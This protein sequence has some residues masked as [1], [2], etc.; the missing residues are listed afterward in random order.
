MGGKGEGWKNYGKVL[1]DRRG[2][3][4]DGHEYEATLCRVIM[5]TLSDACGSCYARVAGF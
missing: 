4:G 3:E 5:V 2:D 1:N